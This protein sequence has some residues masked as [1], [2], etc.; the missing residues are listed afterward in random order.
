MPAYIRTLAACL[1]LTAAHA[2][3]PAQPVAKGGVA[4][5]LESLPTPDDPAP[6]HERLGDD[7][8]AVWLENDTLHILHRAADGPVELAGGLQMPMQRLDGTDL[9]LLRLRWDR[10]NNAFIKYAFFGPQP[11]KRFDFHSWQGPDAPP[12]PRTVKE[13]GRVETFRVHSAALDEMRTITVVLPPG[14]HAD[15]PAIVLADGQGAE[16]W[17][18][19]LHALAED[20]AVRPVAVVGIHSGAYRGTPG[21]PYDPDLDDRGRDYIESHDPDR[22]EAHLRWVTEEVLPLVAE[23]FG[24]STRREDLAIAGFSN[25]GAFAASAGL[26]APH[27]FGH[28]MAFSVGA[29][30]QMPAQVEPAPQFFLAAGTLE[31]GF[32]RGTRAVLDLAR[33]REI[34]A[35]MITFAA[36]H[37]AGM[38]DRALA[39]FAPRV[40]PPQAQP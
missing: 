14:E 15:L 10:W 25:G 6:Y 32:L 11:P 39:V 8:H 27:R 13:E 20:G 3:A 33:S 21:Q 2:S 24:I 36:G 37:D 31:T 16:A 5:P 4:H 28:V 40:F 23:R 1:V 35:E 9:W 26:R 30:P 29:P 7:D 34:P 19:I 22:F 17:S 38:W 12:P 18:R